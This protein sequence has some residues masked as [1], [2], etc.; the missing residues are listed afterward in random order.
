MT[1]NR[2]SRRFH[3]LAAAALVLPALVF[4]QG[5]INTG[6]VNDA[7]NRYGSGGYNYGGLNPTSYSNA[8]INTGNQIVTGNITMGREFRGT[9]GYTDPYAFRGSTAGALSD[10]FIKNSAG[11]PQ[12]YAAPPVPNTPSAFYGASSTVQPPPGFQLSMNRGG[13]VPPPPPGARGMQDQRLGVVDLNA[14][15]SPT[16]TPGEMLTRG[17]L[18]QGN[19]AGILSGSPLYG[20]REWN[21]QDPADRM[22]IENMLNRQNGAFNRGNIYDPRQI[23]QMREELQKTLNPEQQQQQPTDAKVDARP[24]DSLTLSP[25]GKSFDSPA[26]AALSNKP[27]ADKVQGG[28]PMAGDLNTEQGMRQFVLGIAHK[29]NPQYAEMNKR[30]EQYYSD[31]RKTD[32]D[33]A[34]EFNQQYKAKKDAQA[35]AEADKK[36]LAGNN[37]NPNAVRP[38]PLQPTPEEPNKPKVKKPAPV[39]VQDLSTGIK[40][41]GLA[42][43]MKKGEGL[44]KEGKFA[45]ALDQFDAAEQVAPNNPLIW[46]GRA[47]AELGAGFFT[48]A[49]QHLRQAFMTDKSLLMGQYDLTAMLGEERLTKLVSEL[50]DIANKNQQPAPLFL[51]AYVAYNTGHERQA[52]GY[53]DLAEKRAGGNDPFFKALRDHWA[54]P[55]DETKP[56]ATTPD[57]KAPAAPAT[58]KP[59]PE[60]KKPELPELNK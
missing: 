53:L 44:M 15:I 3:L 50:K 58:E 1:V 51:L 59:T 9:V 38:Q 39:K 18:T 4:G 29:T 57:A 5:Q 36:K 21:P 24:Q 2:K 54:L 52:L 25:L 48:R 47:N 33:F 45:S 32:V 42:N 11:V 37:D 13:Y 26:D 17:S 28:Q 31:R 43:L 34:R 19:T 60:L 16:P 56:G 46:L 35:K 23:Q 12:A 22:F 14:P 40:A 10:N 8:V 41:E 7:N 55:E 6:R 30:L 27:N 20:V 49:D